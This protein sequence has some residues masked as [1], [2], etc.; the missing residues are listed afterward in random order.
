MQ[1]Q[2]VWCCTSACEGLYSGSSTFS[3]RLVSD[4]Q[5]CSRWKGVVV[6]PRDTIDVCYAVELLIVMEEIVVQS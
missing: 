3:R 5:V 6:E 4:R 1:D 2:F